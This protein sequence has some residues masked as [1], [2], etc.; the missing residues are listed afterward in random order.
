MGI[1]STLVRQSGKPSGLLGRIM[2]KIMNHMDSGLNPWVAE[3]IS[4]PGGNVLEI[5]CGGGETI[6]SLL[7]NN[8]VKNIIGIDSSFDSVAVAK[9]KNI[10]FIKNGRAEIFQGDVTSLTFPQNHFDFIFAVR[11]HYFWDDFEKAFAEIYRTLK[12]DGKM[13]IF[14][15]KYKIQYH[16]KKYNTDKAMTDFLKT[17]GFKNILIENRDMVQCITASK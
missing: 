8:K 11:S 14:S 6:F 13:F 16:M 12:Q 5:G 7:N 4:L 17:K 9:K 1:V 3:K 2:V 10:S 15:E